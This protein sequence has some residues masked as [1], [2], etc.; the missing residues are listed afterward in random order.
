MFSEGSTGNKD[1]AAG[2]N[3]LL[4]CLGGRWNEGGFSRFH[5]GKRP[6]FSITAT[7][8]SAIYRHDCNVPPPGVTSQGDWGRWSAN[9]LHTG[10][11]NVG[12]GDGSV[13]F[14]SFSIALAPWIAAGTIDKGE[15]D[16]LP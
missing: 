16:S 5:T 3:V 11:V 7:D 2:L 1:D 8:S 13:R 6:C 15:S 4:Y 14:V 9:S 10:G 12:L